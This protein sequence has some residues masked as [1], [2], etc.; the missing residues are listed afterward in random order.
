MPPVP[1]SDVEVS[2]DSPFALT[3]GGAS[4][5]EGE[6]AWFFLWWP[7]AGFISVARGVTIN[8]DAE[9]RRCLNYHWLKDE[10]ELPCESEFV[11]A[12]AVCERYWREHC[13]VDDEPRPLRPESVCY[14]PANERPRS[15]AAGGSL[16]KGWYFLWYP[17][18]GVIDIYFEQGGIS[19][20][21]SDNFV[22]TLTF[23]GE[24]KDARFVMERRANELLASWQ[25]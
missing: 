15:Y 22:E 12:I 10:L 3:P 17:R 19:E 1:E 8:L 13:S 9:G 5:E 25:A 18:L 16:E 4:G 21:R 20:M 23:T 6:Q 11:D 2:A 24:E 7:T 14:L